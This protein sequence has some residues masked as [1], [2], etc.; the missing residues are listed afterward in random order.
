VRVTG[1]GVCMGT[2]SS[3]A[4]VAA[5]RVALAIQGTIFLFQESPMKPHRVSA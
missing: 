2:T 1:D 3:T 4:E 5:C